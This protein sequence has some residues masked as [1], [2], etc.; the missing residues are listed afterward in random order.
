MG[1]AC[2][3]FGF[4]EGI[5]SIILT[6]YLILI[7]KFN[8]DNSQ[9]KDPGKFLKLCSG[10]VAYVDNPSYLEREDQEDHGSRPAWAK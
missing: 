2:I 10:I 7:F 1:S 4:C 3:L 8:E 6:A 9:F 5:F